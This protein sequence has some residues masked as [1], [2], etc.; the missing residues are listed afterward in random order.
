[1]M[2]CRSYLRMAGRLGCWCRISTSGRARNG[3]GVCASWQ[4]TNA[5]SGNH[6][7]ITTTAIPGKSRDMTATESR[8][9]LRKLEWQ[10][11]EVRDIVA[12]T[13]RVKSLFLK[14]AG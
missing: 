6:L 7:D 3:F 12:E 4:R 10:L 9:S 11:T 2:A 14:A 5:V 13:P 8:P 1:M